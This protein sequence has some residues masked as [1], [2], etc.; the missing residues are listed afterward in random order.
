MF[1]TKKILV[2]T[3]TALLIASL[4]LTGCSSTTNTTTNVPKEMKMSWNPGAEPKT[5]DPQMSNGIPEAIIEMSIFEGLTRLDKDNQAKPG[6]AETWDV[7]AD[8]TVY[9]FHLRDAKFSNG[10]AIKAEDFKKAWLKAL[11]PNNA[12]EYAYQL[13]YIK[14]GEEY[15]AGK[16]KAED[17][18]IKVIDDKTLEVT[19]ASATPYFLELTAF[20]TYY[21]N[22][23]AIVAANPKEWNLKPETLIGNGPYKMKE[24]KHNDSI[25]MVK[26]DNYWD[27][28]NV[29]LSELTFNLVEDPKSALTAFEAGQLDGTDNIPVQD[30]ERLRTAGTLKFTPYI[31]TYYYRFNVTRKPFTDVKVREA[32]AMAIDRQTLVDKVLKAGQVPAF[33]FVP[34]GINDAQ[35]GSDFRK[36]GGDFF[37]EDLAKAKQLLSEAGY[38]DGKGFPEVSILFNTSTNH[39]AIAE[40]IQDMW[41]KNLG[42][43]VKLTSQEWAVYQRSEQDLQ[44]DVARAGWIGDYLD[45]MTFMDMF[46][47]NGGNNQTGWSNAQYDKDIQTA[48]ASSDPQVRMDAMHDAEKVLMSE[49]PIMPIYYYTNPYVSK[50]Y[51]K[52]IIRSPLGFIDFKYATVEK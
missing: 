14:N 47:T 44:Y 35:P 42:I 34:N 30:I 12:A 20:P 45:P 32:L 25:T 10:D 41:T 13:F 50:P 33:G 29:K 9:T 28:Q 36:D 24:W 8:K 4:A 6:V 16:A 21:P 38:P 51:I 18:G 11:D 5:L 1:K 43:K 48:K 22:D 2:T 49:M 7:N 31:G 17:V 37:K 19:L 39:Q 26:N 40:A 27:A 15:N 52:N 3:V 46:V 23:S